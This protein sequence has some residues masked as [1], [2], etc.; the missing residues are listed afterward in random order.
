M[1]KNQVIIIIFVVVVVV[2]I[3]DA[4]GQ[5][6]LEAAFDESIFIFHQTNVPRAP[7]RPTRQNRRLP[8]ELTSGR[9]F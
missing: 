7:G 6:C 2:E 3:R 8:C 9:Q 5:Q 1:I 4:S